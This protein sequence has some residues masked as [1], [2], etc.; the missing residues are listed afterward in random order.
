[1][2]L[3]TKTEESSQFEQMKQIKDIIQ[4]GEYPLSEQFMDVV[5]LSIKKLNQYPYVCVTAGSVSEL[6]LP[7][8]QIYYFLK[9]DTFEI[10]SEYDVE[11]LPFF[12]D[13][14]CVNQPILL[15]KLNLN[16][17]RDTRQFRAI[18]G[19]SLLSGSEN[20]KL[21]VNDYYLDRFINYKFKSFIKK[22][23]LSIYQN[24]L[25]NGDFPNI[26]TQY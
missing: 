20:R 18:F 25:N 6:K 16:A 4:K 26:V 21:E 7:V 10:F 13:D 23:L 12:T 1:M 19:K 17:S 8:F 9:T 22:N 11:D 3:N 24:F 5:R 15:G 2:V 14:L